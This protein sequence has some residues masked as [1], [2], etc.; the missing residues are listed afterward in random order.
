[1][2][3]SGICACTDVLR[4]GNGIESDIS[5]SILL[6]IG[7]GVACEVAVKVV[8]ALDMVI[9]VIGMTDPAVETVSCILESYFHYYYYS[10]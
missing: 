10:S 5:I 8:G 3:R 4:I 6:R 1:M 2:R 7:A 9:D